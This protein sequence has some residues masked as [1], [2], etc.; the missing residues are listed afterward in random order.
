[1]EE[2]K[3]SASDPE[4]RRFV[5]AEGGFGKLLGVDDEWSYRIIKD[6]GNYG[7]VYEATFGSKG[8]GLPRGWNNLYLNGGLMV[9]PSWH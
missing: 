4:L 6:V 8:L 5:G 2:K 3:K 9:M 7:E 1:V